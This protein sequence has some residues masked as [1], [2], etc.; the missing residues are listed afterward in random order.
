MS[1]FLSFF[2]F[3]ACCAPHDHLAAYNKPD[4]LFQPHA[5]LR[6]SSLFEVFSTTLVKGT[7]HGEYRFLVD[8]FPR[9]YM[10]DTVS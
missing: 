2:I 10:N 7:V 8:I 1:I 4:I 5:T 6:H 3:P 9:T